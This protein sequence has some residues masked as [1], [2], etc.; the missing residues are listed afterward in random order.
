MPD[1][2]KRNRS[3][4]HLLDLALPLPRF[5]IVGAPKA[6]TTSIYAYLRRHPEV[7]LPE[8]KEPHYFSEFTVDPAFDNFN[9]PV[10]TANRYQELFAGAAGYKA[11]GEGSS[12]YLSDKRAAER[13]KKVVPNAKIIISLRNPIQRAFSH[14]LMECREGREVRPFHETL[15]ADL[16]RPQKGW[17]ISAQYVELGMYADQVERY[18]RC[19]GRSNVLVILFE[20]LKQDSARVMKQI[21]DFIGVNPGLYP[22]GAFSDVH[23]PFAVTRGAY[24]RWLLRFKPLRL[25]SRRWLPRWVRRGVRDNVLFRSAQKPV[26]D[27][28]STKILAEHFSED[29]SRLERLLER[30]LAPLRLD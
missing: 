4:D 3:E 27:E 20:D 2:E 19:F 9:A 28:A 14:Y 29:L 30:D 22:E 12:S 23:N 6:G 15:V 26:I 5:F 7:F 21:A 25:W 24:A 18:I 17:G 10:R 13:I 16:A 8:R 11:V 1:K